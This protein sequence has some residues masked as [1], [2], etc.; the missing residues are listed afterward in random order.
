MD[1][2]ILGGYEFQSRLLAGTGKFS[3]KNLIKPM[4]KSS[5]IEIIT[6]TLRRINFQNP[7]ENILNYIP[8]DMI[9]LP[10]T[11]G[12]RTAIE[13]V[14]IANIAREAG[15]GNFIKIEIINDLKYFMPNNW[16]TIKATKL[17]VDDGFVV[18]PYMMPD[19]VAA[20]KLEDAGAA[21]VMPLGSPIGSNR[22]ILTK[23]LIEMILENNRVPV[24]VDAGIGRPSDAAIAMEMGCDAVLVNTAI[25]TAH[26]PVRMGKAF[27]LAVKA[28]REAYLSKIA[29]EKK[30]ANA[31][32]PLTGFLFGGDK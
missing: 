18:L 24:I 7:K 6:M 28:G 30:Y 3:N 17:L 25:A 27:S 26:N 22:G 32:S 10:N 20:K 11:S 1:K 29:E 15:C 19:I 8:K 23:H 14:K 16:E 5:G 4:L 2:F 31:S 21:A 9:L 12:A 13:A